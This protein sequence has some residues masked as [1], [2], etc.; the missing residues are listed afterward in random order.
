M[1]YATIEDLPASVRRHLP[2]H[3]QEIYRSAFNSAWK[4]YARRSDRESAAHKV[5]WSAVKK[6]YKKSGERW[7]KI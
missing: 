5:A 6:D 4:Q 2:R 1:P 3:A 7:I